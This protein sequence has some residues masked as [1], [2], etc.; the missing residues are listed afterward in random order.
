VTVVWSASTAGSDTGRRI[1]VRTGSACVR[2]ICCLGV[3]AVFGA[4][5]LGPAA[6]ANADAVSNLQAEAAQLSQQMLL[7]QLQIASDQQ[8]QASDLVAVAADDAALQ[9]TEA[10]IVATRHRID[11]DM[12]DLR[13]AAVKAYVSGGTTQGTISLFELQTTQGATDLYDQVMTGNLSAAVDHLQTDRRAL[14]AEQATQT[15]VA[16]AAEQAESQAT[17]ELTDADTK[18]EALQS[19]KTQVTGQLAAAIQAQA[20]QEEAVALAAASAAPTG[21]SAAGPATSGGAASVPA[22]AAV[23]A[24]NAFLA[25]VVKAESGGD[26][27]AVS[28][29]G[30]YMGAFQ[31]SQ[32]T[33][34]EAARL[35]GIPSL[36]GV[37]PND[38][39]PADQDLLAIALYNADGEQPWYDPCRN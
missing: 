1:G 5:L 32:P 10:R 3:A 31:F 25:C 35:A 8:Q 37:R 2:A 11:A 4:T 9:A 15:R 14:R 12:A 18:Q 26:Y 33:W 28:P 23:P 39:S 36:V 27:H 6:P 38:A 21:T 20:T 34:N 24:L 30:Q 17:I 7:E 13:T 29:T 22:G 16:A 19:Q